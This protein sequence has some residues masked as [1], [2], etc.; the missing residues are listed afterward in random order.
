M[1]GG[2][3]TFNAPNVSITKQNNTLGYSE[4]AANSFSRMAS[5]VLM[6]MARPSSVMH[7][8]SPL[9]ESLTYSRSLPSPGRPFPIMGL[10]DQYFMDCSSYY[11]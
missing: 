11:K 4:Y 1:Y 10:E 7:L 9:R 5:Q 6:V 8:P 3:E 2:I